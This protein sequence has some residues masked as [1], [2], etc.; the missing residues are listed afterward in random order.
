MEPQFLDG[1]PHYYRGDQYAV[2]ISFLAHTYTFG[3]VFGLLFTSV[4]FA[5]Y[6]QAI[7]PTS[8]VNSSRTPSNQVRMN[9]FPGYNAPYDAPVYAPPPGPPPFDTDS[10]PPQYQYG[11]Y[12]YG[13]DKD[14]DGKEDPFGDH[15]VAPPMP[16]HWAEERDVTSR[17]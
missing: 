3:L 7:D 10:K 4:A 8:P 1:N 11:D 14:K 13:R 2:A 5:Y 16:T 9:D 6:R 15:G 17:V 12:T